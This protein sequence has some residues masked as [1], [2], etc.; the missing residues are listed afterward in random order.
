MF[1]AEKL[2]PQ[3]RCVITYFIITC[4]IRLCWTCSSDHWFSERGNR[5]ACIW[6]KPVA[7]DEVEARISA[8]IG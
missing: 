6:I 8:E 1:I 4:N 2:Q 5:G 7:G 3:A